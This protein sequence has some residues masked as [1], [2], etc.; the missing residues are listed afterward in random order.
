MSENPADRFGLG[1]VDQIGYVVRD[2]DASLPHYESLFGLFEVYEASLEG[3]L[4][5]GREVDCKLRIATNNA[6]PVEIELI[7]VLEGETPHTEHLREHGEGPQHVRFRIQGI[8]SRIAAMEAAGYRNI[9]FKR[10]SPEIAFS[11]LES[12]Q[13]MGGGIVELLEMP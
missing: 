4:F 3:A 6:G 12:P 10:F 2:L 11:Y 13:E 5:R 7:Q 1:G 9:F 8:E